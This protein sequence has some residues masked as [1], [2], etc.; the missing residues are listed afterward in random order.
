MGTE[1]VIFAVADAGPL[2]HL[3]EIRAISLLQQFQRL[4]ISDAVW[5]ETVELG[6]IA[7]SDLRDLD[8][9]ERNRVSE[10]IVE[11]F[12][13]DSG[14]KHLHAGERESLYLCVQSDISLIL[15]DDLAVRDAAKTLNIIPVGSLGI[16]VRAYRF[17]LI[18]LEMAKRYIS[19][20]YDVSTLFVTPAIVELAV[21][22]LY[23]H[24]E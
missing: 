21:E 22:A 16:V 2:I 4:C 14:L 24:S 17:S 5:Y 10:S 3:R 13:E 9:I 6:R 20:L 18:S 12:I 11:R 1:S 8:N 19:N 15:T 7:E 23:K